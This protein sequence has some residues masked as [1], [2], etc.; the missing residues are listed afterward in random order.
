M[1]GNQDVGID[2]D[3]ENKIIT[4][5]N[6]RVPMHPIILILL[7]LP[8]AAALLLFSFR[9]SRSLSGL[10]PVLVLSGITGAVLTAFIAFSLSTV[11][12]APYELGPSSWG[13][14]VGQLL[15]AIYLGF[16]IGALIAAAVGVPYWHISGRAQTN[17]G[18]PTAP[19]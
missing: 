11:P 3:Q 4:R 16:G 19:C 10:V 8:V 12:I 15:L 17:R 6:H 2:R 14:I 1:Q 18:S 9:R 7:A 13:P 5:S